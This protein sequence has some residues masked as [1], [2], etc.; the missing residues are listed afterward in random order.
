MHLVFRPEAQK[1]LLD[2]MAWYEKR[3]VG[4]GFE[5]ARAVD[6]AIER[7]RSAPLTFSAVEGGFRHL[8][9]RKFPYSVIYRATESEIVVVSCFHHRRRPSSWTKN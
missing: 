6:V 1:E 7:I 4:L 8:M 9:I 3:A 5:F 2:A